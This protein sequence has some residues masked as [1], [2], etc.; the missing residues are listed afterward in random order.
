MTYAASSFA[1]FWG[2][3]SPANQQGP[4]SHSIICHSLDVAAVGRALVSRDR[5]RLSRIASAVGIEEDILKGAIPFL[6]ALHDLGKYARV[7]QA[8]SPEH[9][10]V[11]VLGPYRQLPPGNSHVVAGFHL[12][13]A[14]SDDGPCRHMF[15]Q[16]MPG[17]RANE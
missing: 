15:E 1:R 16:V 10:P 9:W 14:L 5:H 3:A 4:S 13:V 12:L 2:K 17:W 7:F 11:D 8:K 6:L